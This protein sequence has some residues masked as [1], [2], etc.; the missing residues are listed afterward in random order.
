VRREMEIV[1]VTHDSLSEGIGMSQIVPVLLGL[2]KAGFS[3]GVISCEKRKPPSQLVEMLGDQ[4]ILW[5]PI[6]FGRNGAIGG[7]GRIV[8]IG[9]NLPSAKVYHCRGDI[10]ATA[11][12]L[13]T[14]KPF[15]WDVRGLWLD[16]KIIQ[17]NLQKKYLVIFFAKLLEKRSAS[18]AS[19]VSTLTSAVYPVLRSRH[20]KMTSKHSV[21]PT[22]TDLNKFAFSPSLP[23]KKTLLLS[24]VF[25]N[26]YDLDVTRGFIQKYKESFNLLV[27]WCHGVEAVRSELGVGEST[28]KVLTQSDM[29]DEIANSSFG[30]AICK[31]NVGESLLGV[32]PTKVAEFLSTGRPVVVSKGLGDLDLMLSEF[33]AGIVL[34]SGSLDK[35][36]A[37]LEILLQDPSTPLR[38]RE[39]AEKYFSME[40]AVEKYVAVLKGLIDSN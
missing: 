7:V 24:G 8:R 20:P 17:S 10:S 23:A 3:V 16:Q 28:V 2:T 25:N 15:L 11:T 1:Y 35:S 39:L 4:N 31:E 30:L 18:K 34:N 27:I 21:I 32:M 22:C 37:E 38:C 26:Y 12:S 33:K 9:L 13:R 29:P 40:L 6:N 5:K 14:K 36:V 19:A